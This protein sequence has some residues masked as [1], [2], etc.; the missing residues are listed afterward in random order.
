[1]L[2]A[3][4]RQ[5][6]EQLSHSAGAYMADSEHLMCQ[7][8]VHHSVRV[9]TTPLCMARMRANGG[10]ELEDFRRVRQGPTHCQ[11]LLFAPLEVDKTETCSTDL[12]P[13]GGKDARVTDWKRLHA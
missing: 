6:E 11:G 2:D 1:M 4:M 8:L 9:A 12:Q 10:T 5:F 13:F 3:Y 7:Q